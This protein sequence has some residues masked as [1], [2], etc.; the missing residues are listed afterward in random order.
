MGQR[1]RKTKK[2]I[3]SIR[4]PPYRS[5]YGDKKLTAVVKE[6]LTGGKA[7]NFEGETQDSLENTNQ[8]F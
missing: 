4:I 6:N 2:K 7:V 3:P 8:I 5:S 1:H